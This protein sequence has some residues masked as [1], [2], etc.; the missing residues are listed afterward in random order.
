M[1]GGFEERPKIGRAAGRLVRSSLKWLAAKQ[2]DCG[3]P[4]C[5]KKNVFL[6]HCSSFAPCSLTEIAGKTGWTSDNWCSSHQ[7]LEIF[8]STWHCN[9]WEVLHFFTWACQIYCGG[10]FVVSSAA[11]AMAH[12]SNPYKKASKQSVWAFLDSDGL[13]Y[14]LLFLLLSKIW[15]WD[16]RSH[17][18]APVP[19]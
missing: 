10:H 13:G 17:W 9:E 1:L 18:N 6:R 3:V 5:F 14:C 15:L 16:L 2:P 11:T 8:D 19:S 12:K 4:I 7:V